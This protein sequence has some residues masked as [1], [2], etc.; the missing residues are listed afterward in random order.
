MFRGCGK[1]ATVSLAA[2]V[3]TLGESAFSGCDAISSMTVSASLDCSGGRFTTK[4]LSILEL[5]GT[6]RMVDYD[7]NTFGS[8]PWCMS[9]TESLKVTVSGKITHLGNYGFKGCSNMASVTF[10]STLESIGDYCFEGCSSLSKLDFGDNIESV[11]TCAFSG[12]SSVAMIRFSGLIPED[13]KEGSFDLYEGEDKDCV[14]ISADSSQRL[15]ETAVSSSYFRYYTQESYD[16]YLQD[17]ETIDNLTWI[18]KH[19]AV[20]APLILIAFALLMRHSAMRR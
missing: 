17:L 8:L 1:I 4:S 9:G 6:G 13:A 3:S 14:I 18:L 5:I 15:P 12:C 20:F 2:S 7:E 19:V 10:P 11:G 16:Q